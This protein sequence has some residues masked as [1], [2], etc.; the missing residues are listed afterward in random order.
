VVLLELVSSIIYV[1]YIMSRRRSRIERNREEQR[2]TGRQEKRENGK[3]ERKTVCDEYY[4]FDF[5]IEKKKTTYLVSH[6]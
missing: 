2:G 6:A 3:T 4:E 5:L 1:V